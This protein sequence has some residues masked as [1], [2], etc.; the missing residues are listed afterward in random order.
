[1]NFKMIVRTVSA[2]EAKNRF[3]AVVK[4]A[5]DEVDVVLVENHG[6][7]YAF[8]LSP[9]EFQRLQNADNELRRRVRLQHF[10]EVMRVQAE[11][12]KDLTAEEADEMAIRAVREFRTRGSIDAGVETDAPAVMANEPEPVLVAISP[13]DYEELQALR[14][15]KLLRE[16]RESLNRIQ[17]A[18]LEVTR[19]LSEEA[20]DA[21]IEEIMAEDQR[22]HSRFMNTTT[23]S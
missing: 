22:N 2:T 13:A 1:M 7:P 9:S 5:R 23:P 12:N 14:R 18:Q 17:E 20:A 21:L 11:R 4:S 3:G 10:D 15:A 19:D 6:E 16:V 8:I